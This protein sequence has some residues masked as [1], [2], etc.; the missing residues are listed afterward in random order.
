MANM[1]DL[2]SN[3]EISY[4][5]IGNFIVKKE[6]HTNNN[7]HNRL[8][9]KRLIIAYRVKD[10]NDSNNLTNGIVKRLRDTFIQKIETILHKMQ[11]KLIEP[12][13]FLKGLNFEIISLP[14]NINALN[15]YQ[16]ILSNS[17]MF[18]DIIEGIYED[19]FI[20]SQILQETPIELNNFVSR[21]KKRQ[22]ASD[23]FYPSD[24]LFE[25]QWF[26]SDLNY[27]IN[28]PKL[29]KR[30][31]E[32]INNKVGN[33]VV[34]VMDSGIDFEH[35]DLRGRIWRNF[36]EYNCSDGIDDDQNGY[37]DDCYGWNFVD[38]TKIPSD[39]N[40]H[41]THISGLIAAIPDNGLG[42]AGVCMYCQ[43]MVLKV[44][45]S[46][47][48]GYVS[49]I[50]QAI[51]YALD[52]G[53][54][55][56]N[57]SYGSRSEQIESLRL[58]IQRSETQGMLVVAASGNFHKNRDNDQFPTYPASFRFNNVISVTALNREGIIMERAAYGRNSVHLAAPGVNICST[59]LGDNYRCMF[60]SSFST[61]LVSGV[62]AI[63]VSLF[64][65]LSSKIIKECILKGATNI[66]G[67]PGKFQYT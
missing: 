40:G 17:A 35:S 9:L 45:D 23:E 53:V 12:P 24:P 7:S 50:L 41:G 66:D 14:H 27:G 31:K 56:S 13:R 8:K 59:Y 25:R 57:H 37:I 15:F 22:P 21:G 33:A 6:K 4:K 54:K 28:T 30:L 67:L 29:W 60:G 20:G 1:L 36:G 49:G 39:D 44:L 65:N 52:K 58:A 42:I 19:D 2:N 32:I 16:I 64:P 38:D 5:D 48:Q 61:P 47:I 3:K 43:V 63:L 46:N 10:K 18:D 55:V 11:I 26:H 62:A 34:A 51:D